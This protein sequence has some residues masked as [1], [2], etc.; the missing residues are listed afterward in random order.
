MHA[1]VENLKIGT[2]IIRKYLRIVSILMRKFNC[3][4]D[5]CRI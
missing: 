3:K 1:Y 2:I 4:S 5:S